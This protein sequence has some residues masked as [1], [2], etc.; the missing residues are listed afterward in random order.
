MEIADLLH[1]MG[2]KTATAWKASVPLTVYYLNNPDGTVRW[3]WP[4]KSEYPHFL[5]FYNIQGWKSKLF[6]FTALLIFKLRIQKLF[7]GRLTL[8][9]QKNTSETTL[10]EN[11]EWA[12]FTGTPGPNRKAIAYFDNPKASFFMKIAL[13]GNAL[14]LLQNEWTTLTFLKQITSIPFSFPQLLGQGNYH[15]TLSDISLNAKRTSQFTI[16]H[17]QALL[18]LRDETQNKILL[19]SLP[20]WSETKDQLNK[21]KAKADSRIPKGLVR[22]LD[23]IIARIHSEVIVET[24]FSHGDFTPWNMY[25]GENG[26]LQIYDWELSRGAIPFGFDAFHFVIQNGILVQHQ[27]WTEI[28]Q[29]VENTLFTSSLFKDSSPEQRKMYLELYLVINTVYYLC[30]YQEQEE[31][32][33][34][35][36]WLINTWSEALSSILAHSKSNRELMIMDAVDFLSAKR[37]AL[38]KYEQELPEMMSEFSDMDF[39]IQKPDYTRLSHF[40]SKHILVLERK[41]IRKTYMASEQLLLAD[42]SVLNLDFIWQLKRKSSVMM[43]V[44]GVLKKASLHPSG[45]KVADPLDNARYIGLFYALNGAPVPEKYRGYQQYIGCSDKSLDVMLT[46]Y[47]N[48]SGGNQPII[49][50]LKHLKV[51]KGFRSLLNKV[52][53]FSDVV[54]EL[55]SY[56][57]MVITF[58]GVDGAGKSTVI[59][60]LKIRIEK[61]LRKRV[62]V[63]RHRPSLLPILSAWTKGKVAAEQEAAMKLPRQGKNKNRVSSFLRFAYYYFDYVFGQWYISLKYVSRGYVV[64]YDRYYFDFINDSLRSNIHLPPVI[65]RLGYALISEPHYNFFLY[66]DPEMILSRKKELDKSTIEELTQKYLTLFRNLNNKRRTQRYIPLENIDLTATLQLIMKKITSP[67]L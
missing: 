41:A 7:F 30:V 47:Y 39:C 52:N 8:L 66:A 53:Y 3:F 16:G 24:C 46:D 49:D 13:G 59:E 21:I 54:S 57:G 65:T 6:A 44:G 29:Q 56:S 31:W 22:K 37:Y 36:Y 60:N 58:S 61:Q 9:V 43:N 15:L 64:L 62:V 45:V 11:S 18:K 23:L 27:S 38:L 19:S 34:Q 63:I 40:L 14:S 28:Q 1:K 32:H 26:S 17:E 55:I 48:Q 20:V 4:E 67:A 10:T 35:V 5:K 33:T 51:N 2:L 12:V 50:H 42:G 25:T